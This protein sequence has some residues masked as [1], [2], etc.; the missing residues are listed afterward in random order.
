MNTDAT[1]LAPEATSDAPEE[2]TGATKPEDKE[3]TPKPKAEPKASPKAK[4]AAQKVQPQ[5]GPSPWEAELAERGLDDPKFAEYMRDKQGYI[6]QLEQ[7]NSAFKQ[8]FG[9]G[10]EAVGVAQVAANIINGLDQDPAGTLVEI[11]RV[12]ELDPT[13]LF[14]DPN[15]I[16]GYDDE[17]YDEGEYDDAPEEDDPV[18]TWVSQKMQA[19]MEAQ[20]D[21]AY[22][23]II[24][25]IKQQHGGFNDRV[26]HNYVIAYDG[27]IQAAYTEYASD[28]PPTPRSVAPP[29]HGGGQPPPQPAK[30]YTDF[31][32]AVDDFMAEMKA[33][34]RR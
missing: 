11:M 6:T 8:L 20:Q 7:S 30:E 29:V 18:R 2:T 22:D 5:K 17:G 19:E 10:E 14:G 4:E 32:G 12:L 33:S 21:Q 27:D 25:Q 3:P 9:E 34:R 1:D 31:G 13:E 28:F 23:A 26:F 24:A 16:E 15:D